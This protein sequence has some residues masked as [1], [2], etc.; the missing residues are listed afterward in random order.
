MAIRRSLSTFGATTRA[1]QAEIEGCVRLQF[2][3]SKRAFL[4]GFPGNG[5]VL[6]PEG[7]SSL[8]PYVPVGFASL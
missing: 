4:K 2:D 7:L 1:A 8:H 3:H 5:L 6:D